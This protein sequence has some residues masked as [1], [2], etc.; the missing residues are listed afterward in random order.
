CWMRASK[1]AGS[2]LEDAAATS[3]TRPSLRTPSRGAGLA[4]VEKVRRRIGDPCVPGSRFRVPGSLSSSSKVHGSE[5]KVPGSGLHEIT[6]WPPSG[7]SRAQIARCAAVSSKDMGALIDQLMD[8][9]WRLWQ[10]IAH[11]ASTLEPTTWILTVLLVGAIV[12]FM[13]VRPPR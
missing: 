9:V 2:L 1:V 8:N 11:R 10:V 4:E 6:R 7:C 12:M 13:L 5:F 3:T